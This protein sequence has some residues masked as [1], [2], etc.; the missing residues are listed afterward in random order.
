MSRVSLKLSAQ[1][2][3][4]S[5]HVS[6]APCYRHRPPSA[7]GNHPHG[8]VTLQKPT[9]EDH[10]T[11]IRS[12]CASWATRSSQRHSLILSFPPVLLHVRAFLFS[13]LCHWPQA[14]ST[15]GTVESFFYTRHDRVEP[16]LVLGSIFMRSAFCVL[17]LLLYDVH[18][19]FLSLVSRGYECDIEVTMFA[20]HGILFY[21]YS[22]HYRRG[23]G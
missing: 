21:S 2:S 12:I 3:G 10:L 17:R 16:T 4:S 5:P 20:C 6:P 13:S 23:M 18:S 15:P 1:R 22:Y 9:R 7:S 11:D 8:G 19:S 14:T